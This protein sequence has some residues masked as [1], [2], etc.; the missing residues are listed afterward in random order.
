MSREYKDVGP[1][2][3]VPDGQW[4]PDKTYSYLRLV[5]HLGS[6]YL[7]INPKPSAGHALSNG[8][9]WQVQGLASATTDDPLAL[10]AA[11]RDYLWPLGSIYM[12]SS[13]AS[14]GE[15]IGGVWEPWGAGRVP[16]GRD[17]ADGDFDTAG[18]TGGAKAHTHTLGDGYAKAVGSTGASN[19]YYASKM[20]GGTWQAT[21]KAITAGSAVADSTTPSTAI[22]LGGQ[23]DGGEMPPYIVCYMWRRTA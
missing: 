16:V 21:H 17:A 8:E 3:I 14:P 1:V 11:L 22:A 7:Y 23:T 4:L 19:L 6:S 12:S 18:K 5:T 20:P 10:L 9:Y 13:A 2:G 15:S